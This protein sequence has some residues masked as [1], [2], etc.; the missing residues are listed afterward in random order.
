MKMSA[1]QK[2]NVNKFVEI[3]LVLFN[4]NVIKV[5]KCKVLLALVNHKTTLVHHKF[6]LFYL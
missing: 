6:I 3:Q 4:V 1:Q 5:T 2:R